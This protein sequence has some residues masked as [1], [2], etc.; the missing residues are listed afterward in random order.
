MNKEP[1]CEISPNYELDSNEKS[2]VLDALSS[3][4]AD[5]YRHY[6]AFCHQVRGLVEQ[7]KIPQNLIDVFEDFA[8]GN[9]VENPFIFVRNMP[10]DNEVPL[11][12][13]NRPVHSKYELKKTFVSEAALALVAYL[14]KQTP[15]GYLNVN[16]GDVFQDIYPA[17]HMS[18]TQSQKALGPIYFHKDLANHY[19]R[20]DYVNM[21][22]IRST[23]KN[24]IFTTFVKNIDVFAELTPEEIDEYRKVQFYTP[25]DDLT[26][27]SGNHE[28]G[29]ANNHPII[30]GDYDIRYFEN[31]TVGVNE[32]ANELVEKFNGILHKVKKCVQMCPGDFIGVANNFSVH[33][34]EVGD[35]EAPDEAWGRWTMKTVN[36]DS[37]EPHRQYL[38]PG[39]DYLIAG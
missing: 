25:F 1:V 32:Q 38:V 7:G 14:S 9:M 19:V 30:S 15:I 21:L 23:S 28:V 26:V 24:A 12:D 29:T 31:R 2:I 6:G 20:P 34:K 4:T 17:K 10:I 16:G 39:S 5:P 22:S 33:G 13:N 36:V 3:I 18:Q 37:M 8:N 27:M 11:F 35:L